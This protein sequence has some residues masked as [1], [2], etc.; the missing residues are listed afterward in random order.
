M[1]KFLGHISY[2]TRRVVP[3]FT[4]FMVLQIALRVAFLFRE[5]ANIDVPLI[6]IVIV[7]GIGA[8]YDIA[9][10]S[11]LLIPFVIYLVFLPKSWHLGKFDHFITRLGYIILIY[12]LFF[13]VVSEWIFWDEF[14][15][16]YNF[17]AVDYLVY[18]NEVLGN[19]W[20][21]YHVVFILAA[22]GIAATAIFFWTHHLLL[23][24][25]GAVSKFSVRIM[26]G[27][28]YMLLPVL[29]FF[30]V[31][32][33]YSQITLNNYVNEIAGNGIFSLF[34]AYRSNE[35][36]FDKFY[37]TE[38]ENEKL[39]AIRELLDE[40]ELGQ[41]FTESDP[42]DI[43][44]YVP[45]EGPENR[46]NVMMIVMESMSASYMHRFGGPGNITPNLDNLAE[47]SL[48]FDNLYA[49]G[50]RTVRGLEALT[51]SIPPSPGQSILRRP[52]NENLFSLGFVFRDRGYDTKF[53]YG[54]Y[55]YF[56]NMNYFFSNNGFDIVDRNNFPSD[57]IHFANTW[58]V[59]DEDLFTKVLEEADKSFSSGNSFM[60]MVMTTSNHRP[61]TFPAG[62]GDIPAEGGGRVAG[63]EYADYAVGKFLDEAK[64]KP[65]FDDTVFV[66][67]ADHTAG[68]A[69]KLE[70]SPEKYHIPLFIYSPSFIKPR[71]MNNLA[72]QI[73]VPPMLLGLLNFSYYSKFYGENLLE[74]PDEEAH[75][76]ISTY[77]KLGFIKDNALVI[78]EPRKEFEV[79]REG[80]LVG[81]SKEIKETLFDTLSYYSHA[82]KWRKYM[83]RIDTIP[84]I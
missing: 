81:S 45:H 64:N 16:R 70:L 12:V 28:L 35:I 25:K 76:F 4:F 54:G 66:I 55:G 6:K 3:V 62:R 49:T 51:L 27:A 69:G 19:I 32:N 75:T 20:E 22:I 79:F 72:S 48:F 80:K 47:K 53:I 83:H 10:L 50:T 60:H 41:K 24:E 13:D 46:K 77:Q 39:P 78:L 63:V 9:A 11:W 26:H 59:C 36:D 8:I 17:I 71:V 73:D 1:P 82:A 52:G 65:W 56:D 74:D 44:R 2:L 23:P 5:H 21:S 43:T 15:V 37:M 31:D 40:D 34:S 42:E 30:A 29:L 18:T 33:R 57:E 7:F 61:Y 14:N 84:K 68:S 58:G 38:Y 67:I